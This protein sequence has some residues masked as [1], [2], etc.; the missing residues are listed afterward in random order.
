MTRSGTAALT[1]DAFHVSC[2]KGPLEVTVATFNDPVQCVCSCSVRVHTSGHALHSLVAGRGWEGG[3]RP[4]HIGGGGGGGDG[5]EVTLAYVGRNLIMMS[6][7][8]VA[9]APPTPF[10]T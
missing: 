10:W 3:F 5:T 8:P 4:H 6:P 1:P 7:S 9:A 2:H